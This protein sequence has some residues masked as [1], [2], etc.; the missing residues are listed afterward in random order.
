[1]FFFTLRRPRTISKVRYRRRTYKDEYGLANELGH[2]IHED[3]YGLNFLAF[4]LQLRKNPQL[5]NQPDRRSNQGPLDERHRNYLPATAVA[6]K[7]Y[8]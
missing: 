5:E 6:L 8:Y 2:M 3:E 4:V 7:S 1:M